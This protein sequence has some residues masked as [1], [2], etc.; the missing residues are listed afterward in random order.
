MLRAGRDFCGA[1]KAK[2]AMNSSNVLS[3]ELQ[4]VFHFICIILWAIKVA[5]IAI[6]NRNTEVP[7]HVTEHTHDSRR[8]R[9]T[10]I[11]NDTH[12]SSLCPAEEN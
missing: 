2:I 11:E 12:I 5:P 10:Q 7:V 8:R 6:A 4:A 9:H 1:K 3:V